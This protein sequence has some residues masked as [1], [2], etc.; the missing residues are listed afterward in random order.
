MGSH[1]GDAPKRFMQLFGKEFLRER[2]LLSERLYASPS[3]WGNPIHAATGKSI[4]ATLSGLTLNL[5]FCT[6][7]AI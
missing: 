2:P 3:P 1:L 6:S 5:M 7:S 4:S